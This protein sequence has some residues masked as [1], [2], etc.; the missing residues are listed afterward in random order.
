MRKDISR[1]K[2]FTRRAMMMAGAKLSVLGALIG[3]LY[4]L[5]V[6]KSEEYKT[7]SDSNRIKLF[8]VPPLRGMILDRLGNPLAVNQNH[9]RVMIDREETPDFKATLFK[10]MSLIHLD[11]EKKLFLI[12]KALQQKGKGLIQIYDHLTWQDVARIEVHTPD[13]PSVTVDV[14]QIRYYPFSQVC[15]HIIGYVSAATEAEAEKNPLLNHP[16]F[17]VGKSGIE[18]TCEELLQG[19][20]GVR[21]MEVNAHGLI[22]RELSKEESEAGNSLTIT[23]DVRLQ[24]FAMSKLDM[25][26]ASSVVLDIHTGDVLALASTPGFDPNEFPQGISSKYWNELRTDPYLPLINKAITTQYP[27]GSTFKLMVALAAMQEGIDPATI[28]SCPGYVVL[29]NRKFRCWRDGGHGSLNM[30]QAI[31]HSCNVYFYTMARRVGVEKFARIARMFGLGE[32]SGIELPHEKA[33]VVP[34]RKWK[35]NRLKKDWQMGDTLNSGIGQGYTLSTPLQLA[36]MT[37]RIASGRNVFPHLLSSADASETEFEQ[38]LPPFDSLPIVPSAL[39]VIR[40][41]MNDVVNTP[42]G[43]AYGSRIPDEAMPM[44]GKTGTSQVISKK[45]ASHDYSKASTVWENRNHGLFVGFAPVENPRFACSVVIEHGGS[46]S[47]AAAPV[48][49]EILWEAQKLY[50]TEDKNS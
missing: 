14:G 12:K 38:N 49:K 40:S 32:K 11:E 29:G 33:G 8:L 25:R 44:A 19:K 45:H 18:R 26:G 42:G 41:G 46:G 31:M 39:E 10:L 7:L 36:V 34:D 15:S 48:A 28:V 37:A 35:R 9:Y 2:L 3:R 24:N 30:T 47:G 4:Y 5:Q 23:L 20:A 17:K 6:L 43:T 21:R 22:V 27:P 13:L 50:K 16:D 1:F